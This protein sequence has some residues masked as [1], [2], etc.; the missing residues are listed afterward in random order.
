MI[1][2]A[3]GRALDLPPGCSLRPARPADAAQLTQLVDDAYRPYV[4]RLGMQPGPMNDDYTEVIGERDVTV[5]VDE[6]AIVA[7]IALGPSEE[8]FTIDNV[9]VHPSRH[10]EGIGRALL[11]LAEREA[12]RHGHGSIH[13]YTHEKMVENQALYAR[14]GYVE[15]DRRDS[16]DFSRVFM[17]KALG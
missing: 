13:L 15:Y 2:E 7:A 16:D 6:G 3:Y 9:A 8:G 11:A 12:Q 4:E 1:D 17:R 14:L 5:V 10:G